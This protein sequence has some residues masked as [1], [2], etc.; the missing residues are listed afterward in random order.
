[1]CANPS[2]GPYWEQIETSNRKC[3]VKNRGTEGWESE[4]MGQKPRAAAW[5]GVHPRGHLN[6]RH[7]AGHD[8]SLSILYD[9][10]APKLRA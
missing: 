10:T 8:P 6:P 1:V 5:E 7:N 4:F 9:S 3:T 2:L